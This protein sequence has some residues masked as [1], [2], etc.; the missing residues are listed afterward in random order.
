MMIADVEPLGFLVM[1]RFYQL[2]H[3]VLVRSIV[4]HLNASSSDYSQIVGAGLRLH[5]KELAKQDPMG[6]DSQERLA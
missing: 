6:L 2:V 1:V 5:S 4:S 3:Q